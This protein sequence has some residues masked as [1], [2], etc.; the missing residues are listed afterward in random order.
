MS[1]ETKT[2]TT[3][4]AGKVFDQG[5]VD[6]IVEQRLARERSKY[7]REL[8][9]AEKAKADIA[10]LNDKLKTLETLSATA[11]EKDKLIEEVHAGLLNEIPEDLRSLVPSELPKESQIRYITKNKA[12]LFNGAATKEEAVS[13]PNSPPDG[14]PRTVATGALPGGYR[15]VSEFAL[16][17]PKA[18]TEW[19]RKNR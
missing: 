16:K 6:R 9:D 15:T 2:E 13:K 19:D 14:T 10:A 18:F 5:D 11:A 7:E 8:A 17:D 1:D 12:R 3:A 4:A